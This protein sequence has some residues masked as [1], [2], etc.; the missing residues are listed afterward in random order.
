MPPKKVN[1]PVAETKKEERVTR[2]SL[3][4]K[5][6]DAEDVEPIKSKPKDEDDPQPK[7]KKQ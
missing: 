5:G 3:R 4:S 1:V 2:S 6:K 7:K